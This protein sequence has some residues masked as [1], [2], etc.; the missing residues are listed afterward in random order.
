MKTG[1][2]QAHCGYG[3]KLKITNSP[4]ESQ[5]P[6]ICSA[7][8]F[9]KPCN[10]RCFGE[11]MAFLF[12]LFSIENYENIIIGQFIQLRVFCALPPTLR[13]EHELRVSEYRVLLKRKFGHK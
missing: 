12:K 5:T 1:V 6:A 10:Y 3:N 4:F 13:E 8:I 11:Y 9:L 7:V 2:S